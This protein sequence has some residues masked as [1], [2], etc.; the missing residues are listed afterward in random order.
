MTIVQNPQVTLEKTADVSSVDA[1][2]DVI[3]YTI[4]VSN[5]GNMTLTDVDVDDPSV[6]DLAAVESGGFNV[7][8]ADEDGK[9]DLTETW[10][11][12]ASYTVTQADIDNGGVVDPGLTHD[13]TATV[14]TG[15]GCQRRRQRV[16]DDRAEP[17][18]HAGEDRH[19]AGRTAIRSA[20]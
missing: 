10:Q 1:A 13:N 5:A 11:Y 17:A 14:T 2:G 3:H 6:G 9:L 20:T 18:G 16:R 4:N 7:G 12:T 15:A 8:D 19:G